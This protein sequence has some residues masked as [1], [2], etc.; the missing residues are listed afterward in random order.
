M[1]FSKGMTLM[2]SVSSE[3]F[4]YNGKYYVYFHSF[5]NNAAV[6]V[7]QPLEYLFAPLISPPRAFC[8]CMEKAAL[9]RQGSNA[10]ARFMCERVRLK[11]ECT[12]LTCHDDVWGIEG[13]LWTMPQAEALR[14]YGLGIAEKSSM[15]P[16]TVIIPLERPAQPQNKGETVNPPFY[17][18]GFDKN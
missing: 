5:L 8:V 11:K 14:C 3:R 15:A 16:R 7:P 1:C 12:E 13:Q 17:R 9:R 18:F 10:A 6:W 2:D 4:S